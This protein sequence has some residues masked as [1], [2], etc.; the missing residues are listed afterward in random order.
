MRPNVR[1]VARTYVLLSLAGTG[2]GGFCAVL[3]RPSQELLSCKLRTIAN[4]RQAC[5]PYDA[6]NRSFCKGHV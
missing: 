1:V 2:Q 6:A 3:E 4:G 5:L